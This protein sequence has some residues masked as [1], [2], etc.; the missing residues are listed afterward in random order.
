MR[1][2]RLLFTRAEMHSK[3]S[4]GGIGRDSLSSHLGIHGVWCHDRLLLDCRV[5]KLARLRTMLGRGDL[6]VQKKFGNKALTDEQVRWSIEQLAS[7]ARLRKL[8][9][10]GMLRP[11]KLNCADLEGPRGGH[12][13]VG[14]RQVE[15]T[16]RR[17]GDERRSVA[18][19]RRSRPAISSTLSTSRQRGHL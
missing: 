13:A 16:V 6:H 8:G 1:C 2:L 17:Q 15:S 9:F 3:L 14:R 10:E 12:P 7:T 18:G 4:H 11:L 19:P 5:A